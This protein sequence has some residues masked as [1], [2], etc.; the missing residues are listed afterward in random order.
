MFSSVA[1]LI[2][3]PA[4]RLFL[5]RTHLAAVSD[6]RGFDLVFHTHLSLAFGFKCGGRKRESQ[7]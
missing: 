1:L 5:V 4:Q 6:G 2:F 7:G 3:R